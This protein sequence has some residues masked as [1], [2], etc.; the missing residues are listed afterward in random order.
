[1]SQRPVLEALPT[2][3]VIGADAVDCSMASHPILGGRA[4]RTASR[5]G[6]AG[7]GRFG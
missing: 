4:R 2:I 7:Q 1:M 6:V 5:V 3:Y